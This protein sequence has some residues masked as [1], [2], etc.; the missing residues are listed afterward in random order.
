MLRLRLNTR[1]GYGHGIYS[2]ARA[3]MSMPD[4]RLRKE[5]VTFVT[6]RKVS[7]IVR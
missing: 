2:I 6:A 7:V 3:Y 5:I 4:G 1:E